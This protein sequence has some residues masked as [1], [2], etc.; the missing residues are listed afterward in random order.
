MI[1]IHSPLLNL[2]ALRYGLNEDD[3]VVSSGE[4]DDDFVPPKRKRYIL[5]NPHS[6]YNSSFPFIANFMGL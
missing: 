1:D 5:K 2:I 4:E 6:P 3:L